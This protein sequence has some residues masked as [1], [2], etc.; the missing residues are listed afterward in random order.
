MKLEV[1]ERHG[2]DG[3]F[4]KAGRTSESN[5]VGDFRAG[6]THAGKACRWGVGLRISCE[7]LPRFLSFFFFL[8]IQ[9][10]I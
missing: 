5:A 1:V 6:D 2:R 4:Y 3:L 9:R 7:V 10:S 8:D